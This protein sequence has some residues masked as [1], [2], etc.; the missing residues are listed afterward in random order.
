MSG[1]LYIVNP[2]SGRKGS[3]KRIVAALKAAGRRIAFTEYAGHAEILAREAEESTVVAVGG[4]GTVNEVA[5]GLIGTGKT[6]GIIPCGSGDGLA[7]CLGISRNFRKAMKT[8]DEG[9]A[10]P[11]DC[12]QICGRPFFSVCG[13][14]LDAIVSEKFA[15]SSTRGLFT[16]IRYAL[17]T[18]KGFVPERCRIIVDG[19]ERVEDT[20]LVT[21]ANSDQWGNGARIAPLASCGDGLLEVT[22]VKNFRSVDIPVLAWRLMTG[23]IDRSR[24]VLTLKG[25]Q[26][27]I[28]RTSEGPAHYDGDCFS[29]GKDLSIGLL[30][31]QLR[32]LAPRR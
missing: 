18:W 30:D 27:T 4:D 7:L 20:V 23:T 3:K 10:V 17:E 16:Y 11:L 29:A 24:K 32:I 22:V 15:R 13:T 31:C 28:C 19:R 8:V 5:R 9:H 21:V 26:I 1:I 2:V 12:A 6:L 25:R 14:G